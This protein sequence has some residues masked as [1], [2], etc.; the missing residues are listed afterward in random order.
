MTVSAGDLK[1]AVAND[2][3]PGTPADGADR[4]RSYG[5][6]AAP[7]AALASGAAALLMGRADLAD[8]IFIAGVAPVLVVL[9]ATIVH[10]LSRGSF[11]LDIIAA[12]AMAA[13]LAG[14]ESLAA[15]VV[16]LM[17]AGGQ[18]LEQFAQGRAQR[19]MTALLGRLPR[20]AAVYRGQLLEEVPIAEIAANDRLLIRS[21]EV[22]PVDGIVGSETALLDESALTGEPLPVNRLR[23]EAA[24]SG[25]SNAG[26][27]FEL[28][29]IR[30]A[31]QSTYAGVVRLVETARQSKAPMSRLADRFAL[32]FLAVTLVLAGGA[33]LLSGDPRRAI[34]VLVIATPCPLILAV[35]VAI[36][37]GM[38]RAAKRGVLIKS[39]RIL[40]LLPQIRSVILDKTGTLTDGYARL[41]GIDAFEG[42]EP[43][44]VFAA[45]ASLAQASQHVISRALVDRARHDGVLLTPPTDV[46]ETPGDGVTGRIGADNVVIGRPDFVA[47]TLTSGAEPGLACAWK[48]APGEVTLAVAIDG[49]AAGRLQFADLIR[50]D[51]A[52][53]IA[54]LRQG[55]VIRVVM[56]TGDQAAVAHHVG[57]T[58]GIDHVIAEADPALKLSVVR[59]ERANG[60][61]MMVGDGINDA[62]ALAAAH[63]GAAL[64]ARGA[65]AAS[66]AADIV[67]L[68]DRIDRLAEAIAIASRA[69]RIALQSVIAGI[70]L[71]AA[72]MIAAALGYLTPVAGAL[73][74]EVIDVAV[75]L[76]ALRALSPGEGPTAGREG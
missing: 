23:G 70:A 55:G 16:A 71:S 69:K 17:F 11:G 20:T 21:G 26:R 34:A 35:P 1:D 49:R 54:R 56:L 31:A 76:N 74:Q 28:T 5:L 48:Q 33:W 64:G 10:S 75:I 43:A 52:D 46:I 44:D 62:P 73:A 27:P 59:E 32:F 4:I 67:V 40:E 13:A 66:E 14:G 25:V 42:F 3:H 61:T 60:H 38:S 57:K 2:G 6:L 24:A 51:A 7:A 65:A 29:A 50:N 12:L 41:V 22:L 8:L 36:V 37:A 45:A 68:V 72:G 19:D 39:A 58:L 15:A 9:L 53:T 18:A 47:R 63:I 30:T